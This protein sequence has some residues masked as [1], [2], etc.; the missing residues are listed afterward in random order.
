MSEENNQNIEN[1]LDE[2]EGSEEVQSG[3]KIRTNLK[4]GIGENML[5]GYAPRPGGTVRVPSTD[6]GII[7]MPIYKIY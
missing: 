6:A 4:A 5:G 3:L 2:S 1:E 7:A